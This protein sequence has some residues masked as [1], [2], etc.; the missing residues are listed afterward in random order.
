MIGPRAQE[1]LAPW[2]LKAGSDGK[3]FPIRRDSLRQAIHRG[4]AR[5]FPHPKHSK[6]PR[7]KLTTEQAAELETWNK[8]HSWHPNQ[9]RHTVGTEV[10]SR[11]GLE[12]AQVL[13]GHSKAD[14]TQ[15]Y[16][17]RDQKQAIEVAR[18]IG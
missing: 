18:K 14:T 17:E 4:C 3:V 13:L 16:A 1:T 9:I 2:L 10:R 15:V 12:C 5:A 11:F 6:V 7:A 8:A